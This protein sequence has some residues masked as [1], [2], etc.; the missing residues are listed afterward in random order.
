MRET[1]EYSSVSADWIVAVVTV[2][3]KLGEHG[4]AV[5]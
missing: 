2:G 3:S 1:L 5:N 4:G